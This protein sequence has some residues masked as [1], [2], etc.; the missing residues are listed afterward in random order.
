MEAKKKEKKTK[1]RPQ[2]AT[3]IDKSEK[4]IATVVWN[5]IPPHISCSAPFSIYKNSTRY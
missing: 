5:L 2:H 3:V 1:S 4:K